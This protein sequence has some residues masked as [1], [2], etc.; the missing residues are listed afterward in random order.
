MTDFTQTTNYNPLQ[1]TK[2]RQD[3]STKTSNCNWVPNDHFDYIAFAQ[4][5]T[6]RVGKI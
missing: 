4:V 6:R 2:L 3:Y 5:L 1:D